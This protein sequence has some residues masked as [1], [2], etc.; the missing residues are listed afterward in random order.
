MTDLRY[1]VFDA[2]A[3][4]YVLLVGYVYQEEIRLWCSGKYV[5]DGPPKSGQRRCRKPATSRFGHI[6]RANKRSS[7]ACKSELFFRRQSASVPCQKA[8]C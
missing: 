2:R 5:N 8:V 7:S 6:R 1:A 3:G 4:G